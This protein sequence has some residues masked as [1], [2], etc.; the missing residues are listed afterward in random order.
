MI[1]G[2]HLRA[3]VLSLFMLMSLGSLAF[4]DVIV[5]GQIDLLPESPIRPGDPAPDATSTSLR[6]VTEVDRVYF[7]VNTAGNI[8]FDALSAEYDPVAEVPVDL[9]HDGEI[10]GFDTMLLLFRD[11]GDLTLNDVIEAS[12]DYSGQDTNGSVWSLDSYFTRHLPIGN[13]VLAIGMPLL[14]TSDA[15]LGVNRAGFGPSTVDMSGIFSTTDHGDYRIDILG[16]VTLVPEP[17][18]AVL[19]LV[20]SA[21]LSS[22]LRPHPC[23]RRRKADCLEVAMK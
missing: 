17:S 7:R 1:C 18:S 4:S 6:T 12:D 23:R 19:L 14:S 8:T 16:D 9:N 20:S 10:T 2:N 3:P 13:Y 21:I 22:V 15:I 5:E 11:D